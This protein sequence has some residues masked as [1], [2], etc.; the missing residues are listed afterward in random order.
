MTFSSP[1]RPSCCNVSFKNHTTGVIFFGTHLVILRS[2]RR[3]WRRSFLLPLGITIIC[4]CVRC[5]ITSVCSSCCSSCN[6]HWSRPG[7]RNCSCC[8]SIGCSNGVRSNW[9]LVDSVASNC[10][11]MGIGYTRSWLL[12]ILEKDSK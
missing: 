8:W 11:W 1:N 5:R 10:S 6:S 3:W 7:Y 12:A 4:S 2:D 9:C